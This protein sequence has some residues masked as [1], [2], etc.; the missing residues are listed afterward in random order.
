M[1]EQFPIIDYTTEYKNAAIA[2]IENFKADYGGTNILGP[3][4]AACEAPEYD[5]RLKKRIFLLTDGGCGGADTIIA[6]AKQH[7]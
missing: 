4:R 5:S 2:L 6:K 3:L 1:N 7:S